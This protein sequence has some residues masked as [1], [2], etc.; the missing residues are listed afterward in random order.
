MKYITEEFENRSLKLFSIN[1]TTGN[2]LKYNNNNK[3]SMG[4]REVVPL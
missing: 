4:M 1:S 3:G 2:L